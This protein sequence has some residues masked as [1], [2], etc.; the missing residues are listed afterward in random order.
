MAVGGRHQTNRREFFF[1]HHFKSPKS[2]P[3]FRP[4]SNL[5]W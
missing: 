3:S 5:G 1:A 2:S 4:S